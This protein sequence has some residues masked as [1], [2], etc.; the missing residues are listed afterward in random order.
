MSPRPSLTASRRNEI[1]AATSATIA[2]RGLCDTRIA[3]IAD[4]IG[5]SPAL[6]LYYFPSKAALLTEA[7]VYQD[8]V[9]HEAVKGEL[10]AAE[11]A[12]A[13]LSILIEASCPTTHTSNDNPD[14]WLL[15]PAAWEMSRHDPTLAAAR[16]RLD[17]AW[18][19]QIATIVQEGIVAGEFQSVTAS[20]FAVQL[21]ALLDGLAIEV[22]L[23]DS[24]VDANRMRKLAE[25]FVELALK[26][27]RL[28]DTN[29]E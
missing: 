16:A 27:R 10:E 24:T 3:D 29:T 19:A 17:E 11:S 8:Q 25:D 26:T 20:D 2:N 1:L 5:A 18:R 9:F 22:M 13:K 28:S 15:W 4:H 14:G 6:I 12:A 7:L 23:G 21:A